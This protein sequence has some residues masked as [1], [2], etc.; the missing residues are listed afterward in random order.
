MGNTIN[1]KQGRVVCEI[2]R[3]NV[4][5][6]SEIIVYCLS[7]FL[8]YDDFDNINWYNKSN[9]YICIYCENYMTLPYTAKYITLR[10]K[11]TDGDCVIRIN[12]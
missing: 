5:K 2:C 9:I 8:D 4:C 3:N 10:Y 6:K 12:K 7:I 1:N 11:Y